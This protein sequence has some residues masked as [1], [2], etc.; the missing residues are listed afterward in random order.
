MREIEKGQTD[1]KLRDILPSHS[2]WANALA[3]FLQIPPRP[4]TAITSPLLGTVHLVQRE[5]SESLKDLWLSVP[6]DSDRCTVAF[7]ITAF[8]TKIMQS[9]ELATKLDPEDLDTLFFFFP[10]ALQLID[11]DLNIENCNG[12]SGVELADQRDEYLELTLQGRGI[13][14][15][16]IY[17]KDALKSS[18]EST[19]SS[20]MIT[21]WENKLEELDGTSPLDYRIGQA[22]VKLMTSLEFNK[23][24]DDVAKICRD[25]RSA[26][27]IRSASWFAVLRSS[28]L[29]NAVGNRICNE[30]VADSTGLKPDGS[31]SQGEIF[32]NP[33]R[34]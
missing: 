17:S 24:S 26:N 12:I 19:I 7:R 27:A 15:S 8:I 30:L 5:I 14:S 3:P 23:P 10:M 9:T 21:L 22:F 1:F 33:K 18:P 34:C 6:R 16:W 31:S 29:S 28:I 4:S 13:V 20:H 25:A 11:D 32:N 2:A